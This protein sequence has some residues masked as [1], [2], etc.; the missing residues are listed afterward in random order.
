[1]KSFDVL[2]EKAQWVRRETLKLHKRA[3]ET[4]LA[5]SLSDVEIFVVLYY[6]GVLRYT[7]QDIWN[8][9]RDRLIISKGHGAVCLYPILAD[10]HFFDDGEL[11]KIGG[12]DSLLGVIPDPKVPGI[13]TINGSLGHG[14]GVACGVALALKTEGVDRKIFVVSGDGELNSGA[15][16]EA[17][18]FASYHKLGN[19]TLI[20]DNNKM[21]ML[22][23]QGEI[24]GLEPLEE[25]FAAFGWK[26]EAVDGHDMESLYAALHNFKDDE[27]PMP[28]VLI[29]HTRK[30]K[31]VP[32]LEKDPLCHV[33]SLQAERIDEILGGRI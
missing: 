33:K 13:E 4:R 28:K 29:A 14:L 27:S 24:L 19:L 5:S 22:G 7:P 6:G 10:L 32:E 16:W 26:A 25:K 18:M 17:V 15:V 8:P 1:M 20:V 3:P 11:D 12:K 9:E 21:S 30:G 31:G 2:K 23:Y